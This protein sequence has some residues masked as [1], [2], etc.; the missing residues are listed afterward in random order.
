MLLKSDLDKAENQFNINSN[1]NFPSF[2]SILKILTGM[3]ILHKEKRFV[4][5]NVQIQPQI[6]KK[7]SKSKIKNK[8]N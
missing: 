2:N 3:G 1:N 7:V 8:Q 5:R 4:E 6:Q